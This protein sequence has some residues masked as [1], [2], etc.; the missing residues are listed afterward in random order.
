VARGRQVWRHFASP[1]YSAAKQR[2]G[3]YQKPKGSHA[4]L[5]SCR[6]TRR[7]VANQSGLVT[8]GKTAQF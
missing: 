8:A 6:S 7:V 1:H 5:R 4:P 2:Q 3:L